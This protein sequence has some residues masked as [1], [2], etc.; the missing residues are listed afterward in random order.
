MAVWGVMSAFWGREP[1]SLQGLS[2]KLKGVLWQSHYY[3]LSVYE[4]AADTQ[5][6][7]RVSLCYEMKLSNAG[8]CKLFLLHFCWLFCNSSHLQGGQKAR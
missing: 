7:E 3:V 5:K 2:I 6:H 1:S 4:S 8:I